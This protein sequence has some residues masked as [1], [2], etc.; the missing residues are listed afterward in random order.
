MGEGQ[1]DHHPL[2]GWRLLEVRLQRERGLQGLLLVVGDEKAIGAAGDVLDDALVGPRREGGDRGVGDPRHPRQ[3]FPGELQFGLQLG[4]AALLFSHLLG[5]EVFLS[6]ISVH[7]TQ[8]LCSKGR[9]AR[10]LGRVGCQPRPAALIRRPGA[11]R[12]QRPGRPNSI[13]RGTPAGGLARP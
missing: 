10:V 2:G 9:E 13:D 8:L 6:Q 3:L 5:G 11:A 1:A 7:D 4:Q 12:A